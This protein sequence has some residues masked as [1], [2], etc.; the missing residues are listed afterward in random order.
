M[1]MSKIK[2]AVKKWHTDLAP[3]LKTARP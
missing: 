1:L 2:S 3:N